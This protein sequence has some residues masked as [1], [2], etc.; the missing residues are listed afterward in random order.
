MTECFKIKALRYSLKI[1]NS[2]FKIT[3]T[4]MLGQ[5][6]RKFARWVPI[7]TDCSTTCVSKTPAK[8]GLLWIQKIITERILFAWHEDL[9]EAE[10]HID[11]TEDHGQRET[12]VPVNEDQ[13]QVH[14]TD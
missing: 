8:Q 3:H 12:P 1:Q 10:H 13:N 6:E 9:I 5:E 14:D 2:S 4:P 7:R 11:N